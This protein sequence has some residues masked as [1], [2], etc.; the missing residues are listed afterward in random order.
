ME[1]TV[2]ELMT[3]QMRY[4]LPLTLA[5]ILHLLVRNTVVTVQMIEGEH[6]ITKDAKVAIHRL[7]RRLDGHKVE[8]K[9]RRDFGYWLERE[10]RERVAEAMKSDQLELP[11]GDEGNSGAPPA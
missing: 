2:N 3:L 4:D 11:F 7:R 8:I 10:D 6:S 1:N 9:S 5:R